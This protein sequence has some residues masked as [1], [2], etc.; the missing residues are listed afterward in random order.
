MSSWRTLISALSAL[1][2]FHLTLIT[3]WGGCLMESGTELASVV[4][5]GRTT[6]AVSKG[7]AHAALN[8]HAHHQSGRAAHALSDDARANAETGDTG[9]SHDDP[10]P[11]A[12]LASCSVAATA[13]ALAP[14]SDDVIALRELP[15]WSPNA[16]TSV[17][18]APELPPPRA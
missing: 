7:H 5:L 9:R 15:Q 16:M 14:T 2:L 11:C 12:S 10:R 3:S 18:L 1:A 8:E 6:S 4:G 13:A 17:V